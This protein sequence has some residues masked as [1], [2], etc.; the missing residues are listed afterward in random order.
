MPISSSAQ[1]PYSYPAPGIGMMPPENYSATSNAYDHNASRIPGLGLGGTPMPPTTSFSS[2]APQSWAAQGHNAPTNQFFQN[3]QQ[4]PP[5]LAQQPPVPYQQPHNPL[6]DGELGE[7]FEDLYDPKGPVTVPQDAPQV[8]PQTRLMR[9]PNNLESRDGSIG[10]AEGSSIYDPQDP[11]VII[12][13]E[14]IPGPLPK[15]QAGVEQDYAMDDEWEPS[16]P[17]RER[18][19]SYSPYLSPREV[20]RKISMA[21][22]TSHD[23]QGMYSSV[24]DRCTK[25]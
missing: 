17:D 8:A 6:E 2:S 9:P 22:A 1:P 18:S 16:Y 11:H 19:G 23:T 13:G 24:V 7:E 21:K 12:Q 20:H 14:S 4:P 3:H 15:H 5:S 10:D 25:I